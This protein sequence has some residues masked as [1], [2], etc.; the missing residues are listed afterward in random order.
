MVWPELEES[1]LPS[2]YVVRIPYLSFDGN[3]RTAIAAMRVHMP[4]ARES[5]VRAELGGVGLGRG[6]SGQGAAT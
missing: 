6:R 3:R 2:R 1:N 5:M 4:R